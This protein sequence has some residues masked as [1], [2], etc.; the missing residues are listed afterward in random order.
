MKRNT[1]TLLLLILLGQFTFAD[2]V[3]KDQ[4]K[5]IASRFIGGRNMPTN[6][7]KHIAAKGSELQLAHADSRYYVFNIGQ[8]NGFVIVSGDD[9]APE[10]LGYADQ[11]SFDENNIPS[12]M[13]AWLQGYAEQIEYLKNHPNAAKMPALDEHPAIKPMTETRWNQGEPFNNYCPLDNGQHSVTGCSATAMAQIVYYHKYPTAT[14]DGVP[15]YVTDTKK[16][17]V[18]SIGILTPDWDHM[19]L[20]YT[21][22]ETAEEKDA[23][24]KLMQFC[25]SAI[26][27]DYTKN[28][29]A[30][31]TQKV[32]EA[33]VKYFDYDL[34]TKRINRIDYRAN[35]WHNIVY[36]ELANKRPALYSGQSIGGGH[37]FIVDG[38]DKNGLYHINWGWGSLCNGYFLLSILDP[39]SNS[40]IGAS[41][42]ADGYS[43]TQD[44]IIGA[45][46][47]TGVPPAV[48]VKMTTNSIST[49]QT[50]V[51]KKN[52]FFPV[53]LTASFF[54]Q[55]GS[56]YDIEFGVGVYTLENEEK[57]AI[58][59]GHYVIANTW[60]FNRTMSVNVPRLP[61]GNYII[62]IISRENGTNKW[63]MNDGWAKESLF[64]TINGNTMTLQEPTINLTGQITASG[65]M[66]VGSMLKV[67]AEITN[68]G[69]FFNDLITLRMDNTS[70]S[71][72]HFEVESGKT[73]DIEFAFNPLSK[74]SHTISLGREYWQWN[75]N[76]EQWETVFD[77][78]ASTTVD[79]IAA[80][81]YTLTFS[82]G[83]VT[84]A[85]K[86]TKK[87]T[88]STAKIQVTVKNNSESTYNED[89]I[90][91]ALMEGKNNYYNYLTQSRTPVEIS[92][93]QTKIVDIEVPDLQNGKLWF[94]LSYKTNG[95]FI[96][97]NDTQHRY[98]PLYGYTVEIK[99][100]A[101]DID[102]SIAA[103]KNQENHP[104]VIYNLNGQKIGTSIV[105]NHSG[106]TRKG[107]YI[108][109]GKKFIVK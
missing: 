17:A 99:E 2:V 107:I 71:T 13:Q 93:N 85:N 98:D 6:G 83:T 19:K 47:N 28:A 44:V 78:I 61:D 67:T 41:S 95:K 63:Y 1:I 51:T 21:G 14:L 100:E 96:D 81:A 76:R 55:T 84:N 60:G 8:T 16:I 33:L 18:D 56:T 80:K 40:G 82:N 11:G 77:E 62:T 24:A 101:S 57:A 30:G 9:N 54:N 104:T 3:T 88:S 35:E 4:A 25:G 22:N 87:I 69:T 23:I 15:A 89:I 79:I 109:D 90:T 65:N 59:C 75:Q 102:D 36:N 45:Q 50:T 12:N 58:S 48:E 46:P 92:P 7:A 42:S 10:I 29:S 31:S 94:I 52:N 103:D 108:K 34:A 70:I 38:Y 26:Q 37:A 66:E 105:N 86:T 53:T 49:N 73:D 68:N 39:E 106:T 5:Q 20:V 97:I 91:Y 64:A 72:R 74:G 43:Y 27:M 32:A